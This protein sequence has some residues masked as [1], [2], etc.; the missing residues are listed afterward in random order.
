MHHPPDHKVGNGL[1]LP[2]SKAEAVI[3][4]PAPVAIC[5]MIDLA[6]GQSALMSAMAFTW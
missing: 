5:R 1:E 3:V 6:D 4:L 2:L